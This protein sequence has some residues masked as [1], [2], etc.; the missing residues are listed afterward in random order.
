M[1]WY[2]Y[3]LTKLYNEYVYIMELKFCLKPTF[4]QFNFI[5]FKNIFFPYGNPSTESQFEVSGSICK[6]FAYIF[7]GM[8]LIV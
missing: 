3:V 4:L 1:V 6:Y 8:N 2:V 5:M 7:Y